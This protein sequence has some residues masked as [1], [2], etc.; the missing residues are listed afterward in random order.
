MLKRQVQNWKDKTDNTVLLD[1][2]TVLVL[3]M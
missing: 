3:A 1:I 2:Q